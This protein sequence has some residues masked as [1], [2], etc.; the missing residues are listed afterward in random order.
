M[1]GGGV[2]VRV[3]AFLRWV[4]TAAVGPSPAPP[5]GLLAASSG[6]YLERRLIWHPVMADSAGARAGHP[7]AA[8]Q[9]AERPVCPQLG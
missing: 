6:E 5:A 3:A 4:A 9:V 1:G 7:P 8:A 2:E